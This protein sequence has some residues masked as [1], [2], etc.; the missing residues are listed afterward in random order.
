[1]PSEVIIRVGR[2]IDGDTDKALCCC[3]RKDHSKHLLYLPKSQISYVDDGR[4]D[5][6]VTMPLW[7]AKKQ[8]IAD[9]AIKEE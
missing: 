6:D 8:G 5:V 9:Y 4:L 7:L 1:M 2:L 3:I